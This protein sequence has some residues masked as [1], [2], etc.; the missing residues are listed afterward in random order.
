MKRF[1][2]AVA[3]MFIL[4]IVITGLLQSRIKIKGNEI[5]KIEELY[6]ANHTRH[7]FL[8]RERQELMR[9][10][11]IVSYA[12]EHLGMKLLNPD[13]IASGS[14]IQE[15]VE[16]PTRNNHVI[17]SFIDFITPTANAFEARQ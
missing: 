13:Q 2:I 3:I 4:N 7:A 11:R 10:D 17:Y 14:Y 1:I 5:N 15:I 9:R 6:S 12:Q 16:E 8:V